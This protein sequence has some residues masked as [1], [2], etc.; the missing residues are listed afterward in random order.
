MAL[1]STTYCQARYTPGKR[2]YVLADSAWG[3]DSV[4]VVAIPLPDSEEAIWQIQA[5]SGSRLLGLISPIRARRLSRN[6]DMGADSVDSFEASTTVAPA[7][8]SFDFDK[9]GKAYVLYRD[10][11]LIRVSSSKGKALYRKAE[12]AREKLVSGFRIDTPDAYINTLGGAL[13]A[14]A[15]GIWD[16]K[17]W[18][19]GANGWRMPLSGWRAA[20]TGDC[21]GWFDRA[22][23]HFDNYAASQVTEVPAVYSHP[24][25]DSTMNLARAAKKWG[26][27]MYSN[28]YICRNPQ[29]TNQMHHYD[30]NLC[31]VD[32][33]LWHLCWTGD[34]DYARKM[35]PVLTAHLAW[36][37]RNFDP[38]DDG[39]YDAYC[40]IWASDALYYNSGA[41]TH[42]SAY[43][44]RANKLAALIAEKIGE[45]GS[46]YAREA[47]RIK[48]ALDKRLWME[49]VGCWAEF[50]DFMG[51]K[52]LHT[53][54]AIWTVYHAIDSEVSDQFQYYQAADYVSRHIPRIPV[55][56]AGLADSGYY[57]ISTTNW[58]PYSWSINNVAFAEVWH[59]CLAYWQAGRPEEAFRLFKS[60]VLDGMYLGNSP[61]NFGQ[62]SFYDAAR[63]ECYR[64]FGDPIGV[65]SR[66]LVQGLFG[67][68]PDLLNGQ[69][70][71]RPG[72]PQTWDHAGIHTP[73]VDFTFRRE[74]N[75]DL[76]HVEPRFSKEAAVHLVIPAR[77]EQVKSIT[78]NGQTAGYSLVEHIGFPCIR[79][80]CPITDQLD[81]EV[82]WTGRDIQA[83]DA[84]VCLDELHGSEGDQM[85]FARTEQGDM[86]WWTPLRHNDDHRN[87]P[88]YG[89]TLPVYADAEY[90]PVVMDS[91]WN[92][93]VTDIFRNKYDGPRSP[94]TTLQM[95]LQGI[96]DWCHPKETADIDDAGIRRL[97]RNG[98]FTIPQG[99]PFRT[100]AEGNNIAYTS[101]WDNYPDSV[102]CLLTGRA[103]G[104]YLLLAGSTNHMQCR[105]ENGRVTVTY[106]DGSQTRLSLVNP[107][108]WTPIEQDFYFDGL[109]F[110]NNVPR[111]YRVAL[112]S[113][114]VSNCLEKDLK[115]KGF[116]DRR[117]PGGAA[118]LL[119]L[120]LDSR[121]EL[122]SL[123]V[124]TLS[125]DV[126]IGLMGATLLRP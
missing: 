67:I 103:A 98:V 69:V 1:D 90:V 51:K 115:L 105:I 85:V 93:S 107:E 102:S 56:A 81:I 109:A 47:E 2:T 4:R 113:G 29:R 117:I 124:E 52:R 66:A 10:G 55:T 37:K 31:Y 50:Q 122:H 116:N 58:M 5:P 119:F 76:Y 24:M 6:G 83:H 114:L 88:D 60:S 89:T 108:N 26:T 17:V 14:A 49:N 106:K 54:P 48:Q 120:P 3:T 84:H 7:C 27:Q 71:I 77:K 9:E 61:G 123:R 8:T 42:S 18:L 30:M 15:D 44:Y 95:P 91:L 96:G 45:D 62:I 101:L 16:G 21:L 40:C 74:D 73:Y 121:K 111:P 33:L 64:D 99:V 34:T 19:H 59:M 13:V 28:G 104:V 11:K 22:R 36:E 41:V 46:A 94:Y 75:S 68:L 43:N 125:N 80:D 72:F 110:R 118:T 87:R 20:Y 97:S 35:W 32:E 38:D 86:R 65:A 25:Q 70:T 126:V 57:T 53:S 23:A 63:G 112:A 82:C 100:P 12:S 78:I 79:I 39:L 92:S